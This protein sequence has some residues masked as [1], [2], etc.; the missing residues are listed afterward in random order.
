MGS[1]SERE[2]NL[3]AVA[4]ER[5]EILARK[6]GGSRLSPSEQDRLK[7]LTAKLQ[8]LLPPVSPGDL[9]ALVEIAEEGERIRRRARERRQRLDPG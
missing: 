8:E 3:K 4:G 7:L 2:K 6:H 5:S 1:E 9:K